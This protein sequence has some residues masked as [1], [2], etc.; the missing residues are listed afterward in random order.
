[1]LERE[2]REREREGRPKC[3]NES[4]LEDIETAAILLNFLENDEETIKEDFGLQLYSKRIRI[5]MERQRRVSLF[6]SSP[7]PSLFFL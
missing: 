3:E 7:S 4:T 2:R 6:S 5:Y 1:L